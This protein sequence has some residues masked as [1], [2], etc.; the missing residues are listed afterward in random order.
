V[1]RPLYLGRGIRHA[2]V[3]KNCSALGTGSGFRSLQ[4]FD[5]E[6][7]HSL[8]DRGIPGAGNRLGGQSALP[9]RGADL[10]GID[11]NEIT[12]KR[13]INQRSVLVRRAE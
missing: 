11:A 13:Y 10:A 6:G 9:I 5:S 7:L 3:E 1:A 12:D 4:I 2:P 8:S